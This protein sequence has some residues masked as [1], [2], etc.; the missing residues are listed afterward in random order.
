[1]K[2]GDRVRIV[3]DE[4]SNFDS[5]KYEGQEGTYAGIWRNWNNEECPDVSYPLVVTV[6]DGDRCFR[7]TEVEPVL[8]PHQSSGEK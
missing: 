3:T 1:M 7:R 4:R 2:P 6:S 8:E 5:T